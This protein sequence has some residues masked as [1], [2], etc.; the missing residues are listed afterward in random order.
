V[1]A[2]NRA[3]EKV[4]RSRQ[5]EYAVTAQSHFRAMAL[6]TNDDSNNVKIANAKQGFVENLDAVDEV[7]P[8]DQDG[9]F[10]EVRETNARFA[11]SGEN[12]LALYTDGDIDETLKLHIGQEHMI[13]HELEA[14]MRELIGQATD[15]AEVA[16]AEFQSD[17]DTL[18]ATVWVFFGVSLGFVLLVG[19]V[20]SLAFVR[21][22]RRIDGVVASV[23]GGPPSWLRPTAS[24]S[25]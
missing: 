24:W 20:M 12:V 19:I 17:K 3:Q 22:I 21:P 2:L 14:A 5:M 8:P 7:S 4:D 11:R 18:T 25:R 15:E 16:T 23:A 1:D 13:S 6:L 9:F 10:T